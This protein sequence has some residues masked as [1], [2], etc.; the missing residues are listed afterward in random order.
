L[1]IGDAA[2]FC[3]VCG[4][5]VGS[6]MDRAT[7]ATEAPAAQDG[8]SLAGPDPGP[9]PGQDPGPD[10]G[11]DAGRDDRPAPV[12][13]DAPSRR[14]QEASLPMRE[15]RER[16]KADPARAAAL[17]RDAIVGL[18]E[19]AADPL[20]HEGVRRDLLL[21]FDRLSLVLKRAGLPAEALEEIECAA[22]L[23]LL[24]C[25]DRGTKGHREA[26]TRRRESLRRALGGDASR[27]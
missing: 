7:A 3:T 14:R 27:G 5:R 11:Q 21:G 18:L 22:S 1:S 13:E 10:P 23:G 25:R 24:D 9:D 4:A 8:A 26:L 20:Q 19:A 15:A 2:T 16:E 17:Y 6:P 12:H